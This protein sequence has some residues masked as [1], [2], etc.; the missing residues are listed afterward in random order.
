MSRRD[1]HL[2]VVIRGR[3]AQLLVIESQATV[4][5]IITNWRIGTLQNPF[6]RVLH[7]L[8]RAQL[9]YGITN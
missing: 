7:Y 8:A 5:G 6:A 1:P 3:I 4:V 2:S 9:E